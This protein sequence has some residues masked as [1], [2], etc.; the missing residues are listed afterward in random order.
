MITKQALENP[1]ARTIVFVQ[2][3]RDV[4]DIADVLKKHYSNVVALTGTIRGKERDELVDN[5]VF[6]AFTVPAEPTE[7]HFLVATSAGE[8]GIDL[9]CTRMVTDASSAASLVQRF[10]RCNRF[11]EA[12][13][14]EIYVVFKEAEVKKTGAEEDYTKKTRTKWGKPTWSSSSPC[15]VMPRAGT[16][17]R[18]VVSWLDWPR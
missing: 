2:S 11:A 17:T 15:M 14:S 13:N 3:P 9:T 8:V 12:K 16:C 7:P 1:P 5:P 4:V 18:S 6:Q 10:G